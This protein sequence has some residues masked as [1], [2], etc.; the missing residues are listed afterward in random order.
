VTAFTNNFYTNGVGN[1]ISGE[2]PAL[3]I[4]TIGAPSL[5]PAAFTV[6]GL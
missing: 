1:F 6:D 2:A 4:Q 5:L 3:I